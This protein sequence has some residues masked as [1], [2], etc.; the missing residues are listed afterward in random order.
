MHMAN[1]MEPDP[2]AFQA[3]EHA[4]WQLAAPRY[5]EDFEQLTTQTI[6]PLL[7]ATAVTKG[8][9]VLDVATGPGYVARAAGERGAKVVGIDFSRAMLERA[10]RNAPAV[11]FREADA[12]ALPFGDATFEVVTMNYGL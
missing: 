9:L 5:D 10:C 11:E 12:A 2:Q 4:G 7:T 8:T 1:S 6:E 3:F